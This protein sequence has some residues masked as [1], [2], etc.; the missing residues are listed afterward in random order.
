MRVL[1]SS[2]RVV[3]AFGRCVC[4][5]ILFL[6]A[7]AASLCNGSRS[8][9]SSSFFF[10]FFV[11]SVSRAVFRA[12]CSGAV[13]FRTVPVSRLLPLTTRLCVCVCF[14]FAGV[15]SQ[16]LRDLYCCTVPH[17]VPTHRCDRQ[18]RF[19]CGGI[20]LENIDEPA[21]VWKPRARVYRV[22]K[23]KGVRRILPDEVRV[24]ACAQPT[25]KG[26]SA[27]A[28]T[29]PTRRLGLLGRT[30]RARLFCCGS[31]SISRPAPPPL[32]ISASCAFGVPRVR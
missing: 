27:R 1:C 25:A 30:I 19:V 21:D 4:L 10:F 31:V 23:G 6:E 26:G 5:S 11:P 2:F 22:E 28:S 9:R 24:I 17:S 20:N 18:G 13:P 14:F 29:T 8:L 3:L 16:A 32:A 15:M 12:R 7:G